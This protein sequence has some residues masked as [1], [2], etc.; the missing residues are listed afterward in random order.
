MAT[1]DHHCPWLG[2]CIGER[3]KCSFYWYLIFQFLELVL[4]TIETIKSLS[5]DKRENFMG[6]YF[7][8]I[9]ALL[10]IVGFGFM[11]MILIIYHTFLMMNNLTTWENVSWYKISYLKEL[12]EENGSPFSEGVWNNVKKY[13]RLNFF[14]KYTLENWTYKFNKNK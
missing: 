2:T 12:E 3:N 5:D 14:G 11:V 13:C 10:A 6:H 8:T 9:I 1:Y 4:P 7:F